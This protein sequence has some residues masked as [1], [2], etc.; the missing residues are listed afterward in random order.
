MWL[1]LIN[2]VVAKAKLS[3]RGSVAPSL[4]DSESP[5]MITGANSEFRRQFLNILLFNRGVP[6]PHSEF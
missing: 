1:T 4:A 5:F 3:V 2:L 6:P